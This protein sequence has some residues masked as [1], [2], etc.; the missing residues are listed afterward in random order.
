MEDDNTLLERN[1]QGNIRQGEN[2]GM[3]LCQETSC[4]HYTFLHPAIGGQLNKQED[5]AFSAGTA[6]GTGE[7]PSLLPPAWS[8]YFHTLAHSSAFFFLPQLVFFLGF[9]FTH[10]YHILGSNW[11]LLLSSFPQPPPMV[12]ICEHPLLGSK[13][14][15]LISTSFYYILE[16][17]LSHPAGRCCPCIPCS[18]L[19][20]LLPAFSPG[21]HS[22]C[23][24]AQPWVT[25]IFT[26]FHSTLA[27]KTQ[28]TSWL[29]LIPV[30]TYILQSSFC[31]FL[32]SDIIFP[33]R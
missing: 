2:L 28:D 21:G 10:E 23:P 33:T 11:L 6:L 19:L 17:V 27:S 25:H 22:G 31:S 8:K 1:K 26:H 4:I 13:F 12:A 7:P 16:R 30:S 9:P 20:W 18:M 14:P 3:L 24:M 29:L 32:L 15:E 5:G